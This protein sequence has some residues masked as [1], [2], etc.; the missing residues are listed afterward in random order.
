MRLLDNVVY[1]GKHAA[2]FSSACSADNC[3]RDGAAGIA[4]GPPSS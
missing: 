1:D 3:G 2:E 4:R